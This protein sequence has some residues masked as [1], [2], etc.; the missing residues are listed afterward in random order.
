MLCVL[1]ALVAAAAVRAQSIEYPIPVDRIERALADAGAT[2]DPTRLHAAYAGYL[3]AMYPVTREACAQFGAAHADTIHILGREQRVRV[4]AA[5]REWRRRADEAVAGL[6]SE[7][8]E[9]SATA[10]R[11]VLLAIWVGRVRTAASGSADPFVPRE[12]VAAMLASLPDDAAEQAR[13]VIDRTIDARIAALQRLVTE[14]E[15]ALL[16]MAREAERLG[17]VGRV[18]EEFHAGDASEEVLRA[19]SLSN[20]NVD[21]VRGASAAYRKL[22]VPMAEELLALVPPSQRAVRKGRLAQAVFSAV[23]F[24]ISAPDLYG[25][26]TS[27]C[28]DLA[29]NVL[30]TRGIPD[31]AR[32]KVVDILAELLRFEGEHTWRMAVERDALEEAAYGAYRA[33]AQEAE[34]VASRIREAIGI[35]D[36]R[37]WL[38]E[39][40]LVDSLP[41]D[42]ELAMLGI[43]KSHAEAA[44]RVARARAEAKG[45]RK[46][47]AGA[48]ASSDSGAERLAALLLGRDADEGEK[49][50][51]RDLLDRLNERVDAE[52]RPLEEAVSGFSGGLRQPKERAVAIDDARAFGVSLRT[53]A[54]ARLAIERAFVDEVR[55]AMGDDAA[56]VAESMLASS[57]ARDMRAGAERSH[58]G[59]MFTATFGGGPLDLDAL[60]LSLD[61]PEARAW[62]RRRLLAHGARLRACG[63]AMRRDA[64]RLFAS[65]AAVAVSIP[66]LQFDGEDADAGSAALFEAF[67]EARDYVLVDIVRGAHVRIWIGPAPR[68]KLTGAALT[69]LDAWRAAEREAFAADPT[70]EPG[71]PAAAVARAILRQRFA[72]PSEVVDEIERRRALV[73]GDPTGASLAE[74]LAASGVRAARARDDAMVVFR[75]PVDPKSIADESGLNAEFERRQIASLAAEQS[76]WAERRF[77]RHAFELLASPAARADFGRIRR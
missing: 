55:A 2:V 28:A 13:S 3:E 27:E 72:E 38:L 7:G 18:S 41:R 21:G 4:I 71:D 30:L 64:L 77:A 48:A 16:E 56:A 29:T 73:R 58:F 51:V 60:A 47:G 33:N 24:R 37:G 52:V 22:A 74:L 53:A 50:L 44:L 46:P 15:A 31:D 1:P 32:A 8:D 45:T 42:E 40:G 75:S 59:R 39:S 66:A 34:A 14:C 5:E 54:P 17:I 62:L 23:T 10:H 49:E 6:F 20:F 9:A 68:D 63:D 19:I 70:D 25:N 67:P 76:L 57:A 36:F 11:R 65:D 35:A 26:R 12:D 61:D 43:S 69:S